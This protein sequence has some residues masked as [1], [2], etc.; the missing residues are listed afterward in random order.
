MTATLLLI[1]LMLAPPG[2][3]GN[4]VYR[5]LLADGL[6]VGEGGVSF[7]KP[8][9][10][11]G[12]TAE[13]ER[14]ALVKIAGSDRRLADLTRDSVSAPYILRTRD[15]PAGDAGVFRVIDLWF[16][17]R[18]GLD[19]IDPEKVV[20]GDADGQAVE[21][22]NMSFR[23]SRLGAD[24]LS[25]LGIK[26]AEGREWYA[27][28]SGRLLDRIAVEVTDRVTAS[29]TDDSWLIASKADRR[30]DASPTHPN[31]WT[32][33]SR[34]G[35]REPS[36]EPRPYPGGAGYVKISRL[37]TVPGALLAEAHAAFFE[38]RGWFDGAPILRS[39]IS[40][41]AQDRIRALRRE[42]ARSR[43]GAGGRTAP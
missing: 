1:G 29:R 15:V 37:R 31:R 41:V 12:E 22:G 18:A 38:P 11:G 35:R 6:R 4:P 5:E 30:F 32:P 43:G 28:V 17:V 9:L 34:P 19:E 23:A 10:Q 20:S 13:A 36:G 42:L 27:H 14:A 26:P 39:K 2:H 7:P 16:V 24:D 8:T 21:A 40:V 25:A 3:D 33:L